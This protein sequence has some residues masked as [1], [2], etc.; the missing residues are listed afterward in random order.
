[1]ATDS[2]GGWMTRPIDLVCVL[3][4]VDGLSRPDIISTTTRQTMWTGSTVNP[5]LVRGGVWE[6]GGMDMMGYSQEGRWR[7]WV[8]GMMGLGLWLLQTRILRT[9]EQ[10]GPKR[11]SGWNY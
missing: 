9:A 10:G 7:G 8:R 3:S 1:M 2:F 11:L 5:G 4:R 6:K